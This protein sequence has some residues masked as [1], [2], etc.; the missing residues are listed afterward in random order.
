[1][2]LGGG[3]SQA[4]NQAVENAIRS[5]IA[6]VAAAGN[7]ASDACYTSPASAPNAV[8]VAAIDFAYGRADFSNYGQCADIFAPGVDVE[9]AWIGAKDQ[10]HYLSGTS[11][12]APHV[13]GIAATYIA[14]GKASV[15]NLTQVL[16]NTS[17]KNQVSDTKGTPNR[18]ANNGYWLA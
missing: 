7:N 15:A 5:N 16:I 14:N 2:S 1:M 12:A 18:I 10:N 4:L 6:V 3:L 9:S 11:M 17:Q 8:T 13:A